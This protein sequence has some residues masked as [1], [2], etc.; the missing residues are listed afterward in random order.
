MNP[1]I[2][3]FFL[4]LLGPKLKYLSIFFGMSLIGGKRGFEFIRVDLLADATGTSEAGL[5]FLLGVLSGNTHTRVFFFF[6]FTGFVK[7]L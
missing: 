5:R 4:L 2:L 3:T 7:V 6:V 1:D